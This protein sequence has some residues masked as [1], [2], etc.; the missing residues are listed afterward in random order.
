M[1][2]QSTINSDIMTIWSAGEMVGEIEKRKFGFNAR[3]RNGMVAN[4]GT[5]EA[6]KQLFEEIVKPNNLVK[7]NNQLNLF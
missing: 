3:H 2:I 6:A 5:F 1:T 7:R 4:F